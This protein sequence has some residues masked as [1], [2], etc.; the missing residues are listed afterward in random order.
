MI[1]P[2]NNRRR[3]KLAATTQYHSASNHQE[4]TNPAHL[5]AASQRVGP[6]AMNGRRTPRL[7]CW[8]LAKPSMHNHGRR[9]FSRQ[10]AAF[11]IIF[12][13]YGLSDHM[14]KLIHERSR[15]TNRVRRGP[16]LTRSDSA[17]QHPQREKKSFHENGAGAISI[18]TGLFCWQ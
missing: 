5:C 13:R 15:K 14:W 18:A 3:E 12:V 1:C 16:C 10:A 4:D 2:A 6:Q 17:H 8:V 9:R 11:T 7:L